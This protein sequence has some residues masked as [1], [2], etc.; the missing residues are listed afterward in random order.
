M[1][2][3]KRAAARLREQ[4]ERNGHA[5]RPNYPYPEDRPKRPPE[6][7][8]ESCDLG[9]LLS[10]VKPQRV[11]WFWPGRI[12]FG[13]LTI[14]DGDPGL[15]KSVLSIDLA[16]RATRGLSLPFED[17][18]PGEDRDPVGVILLSAEDSL[19]DTIRPRLDA[20][21]ADDDRVLSLDKIPD[22]DNDR[23]PVL[24][25]DVPYV[26]IACRQM[27]AGLIIVDPLA[28]FLGSDTDTHKDQDCRRALYPLA[29]M[30]QEMGT[31][32]V[33]IRHLNKATGG[34]PLYRGGGSIGII[35]AARSGLL[36]ARDPDNPDR[37]VLASTKCNLAKLPTSLAF[38]LS[39][40]AN[41][42]LRVGWIG[43]SAHTAE[44]LLAAAHDDEDR[45][46][47]NDAVEVLR[48]ILSNGSRPGKDVKRE[49]RNAGVAERTLYRAKAVLGVQST[50]IG[51]G[52]DG[53]WRWSLPEAEDA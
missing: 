19:E 24:P 28:A 43:P 11:N 21:G 48:V 1:G 6:S 22:G 2:N 3:H 25:N 20:A 32:I 29:V 18:E 31:A 47:V 41:G 39:T 15:G 40:A 17:R 27:N 53:E 42:A 23:L 8:G 34:N 44:S 10:T 4:A 7:D 36:V 30:A 37:R 49:A 50:L 35:G 51:F 13:K 14:L 12:P 16:A 33:V 5:A 9:T 46:T 52:S 26:R 38:D 45:G